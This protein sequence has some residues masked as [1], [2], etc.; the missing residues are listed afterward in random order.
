MVDLNNM[1]VK[2]NL[3]KNSKLCNFHI[4]VRW[5]EKQFVSNGH[6]FKVIKG[7]CFLREGNCIYWIFLTPSRCKKAR[8]R[9]IFYFTLQKLYA[10]FIVQHHYTTVSVP[11]SAGLVKVFQS[12]ANIWRVFVRRACCEKYWNQKSFVEKLMDVRTGKSNVSN[13]NQ[14]SPGL[15]EE[16]TYFYSLPAEDQQNCGDS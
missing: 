2:G 9:K 10:S 11:C 3:K 8:R 13:I 16:T 12:F 4:G 1:L 5:N 15:D 7:E 14:S 6:I